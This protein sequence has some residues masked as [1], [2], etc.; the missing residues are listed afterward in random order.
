MDNEYGLKINEDLI[1]SNG[2]IVIPSQF[3]GREVEI[4]KI[5]SPRMNQL[6]GALTRLRCS[7]SKNNIALAVNKIGND[8]FAQY[9]MMTSN[10]SGKDVLPPYLFH[11]TT[12]DLPLRR[13][14]VENENKWNPFEYTPFGFEQESLSYGE[15]GG[16]KYDR[17]PVG[18]EI[19]NLD[20]LLLDRIRISVGGYRGFF[21]PLNSR[22]VFPLKSNTCLDIHA[23]NHTAYQISGELEE[24]GRFN[25]FTNF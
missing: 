22:V 6:L 10:S 9:M 16:L 5:K 23:A 7:D 8:F 24:T 15:V 12:S 4:G 20:D 2:R 17:V 11:G 25:L 13:K 1:D 21:N 19:G 18:S 3:H 14:L